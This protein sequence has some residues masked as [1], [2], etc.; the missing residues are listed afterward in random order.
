VNGTNAN[1]FDKENKKHP[2]FAKYFSPT[3]PACIAMESEWDEMCKDIDAKYNTD[4]I[5]AQ[6]DP[7][8]MTELEKTNTYSDVQYVPSLIVLKNGKKEMEYDGP[9][10]KEK[11]IEFLLQNGLIKSKSSM[12][13]CL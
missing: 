13:F 6:I 2:V 12:F 9:K 3:C 1:H 4:M 8:G 10:D 5:M 11:M 7:T